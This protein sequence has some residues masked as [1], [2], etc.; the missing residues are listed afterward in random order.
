MVQNISKLNIT[1][2]VSTIPHL[3]EV[4]KIVF[5][6]DARG[7]DWNASDALAAIIDIGQDQTNDISNITMLYDVDSNRAKHLGE[8]RINKT[9]NIGAPDRKYITDLKEDFN[10][11]KPSSIETFTAEDII[12]YFFDEFYLLVNL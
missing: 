1:I 8:N 7:E 11:L 4:K 2:P 5:D 12:T 6:Y 9:F 10:R 3:E